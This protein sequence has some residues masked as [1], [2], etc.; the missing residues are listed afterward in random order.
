VKGS[1]SIGRSHRAG[2]GGER[3]CGMG[4]LGLMDR[5]AERRGLWAALGFPFSSELLISFIFITLLN[6]NTTKPQIQI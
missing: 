1:V 2:S 6:S 5:K 3:A 4:E